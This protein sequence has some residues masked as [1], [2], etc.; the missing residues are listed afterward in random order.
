M[1]L[2]TSAKVNK[3]GLTILGAPVLP[4]SDSLKMYAIGK[5]IGHGAF[6]KRSDS[7]SGLQC[8]IR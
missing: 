3:D 1:I 2:V 8:P 7:P 5:Y 4:N 6:D